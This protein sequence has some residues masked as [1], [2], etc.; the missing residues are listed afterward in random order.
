MK[1]NPQQISQL[2]KNKAIRLIV[3]QGEEVYL[4]EQYRQQIIHQY[5]HLYR[6]CTRV[7]LTIETANDW[8]LLGEQTQNYSLFAEFQ[9]FDVTYN[10]SSLDASGKTCLTHLLSSDNGDFLVIFTATN[11]KQVTALKAFDKNIAQIQAWSLKGASLIQWIKQQM[12]H[13]QL[14]CEEHAYALIAE[15]NEGNLLACAQTIEKLSLLHEKTR[16]TLEQVTAGLSFSAKFDVFKLAEQLLVGQSKSLRM[17]SQLKASG[18][19]PS[20]ILWALCKEI[21]T[22][23]KLHASMKQ[24]SLA[25]AMKQHKIWDS[26]KAS[27]QSALKRL[28]LGQCYHLLKRAQEVDTHIKGI[29]PLDPWLSVS[30]LCLEFITPGKPCRI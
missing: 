8:E 13:H 6:D 29:Q 11:L 9:I 24:Q 2:N 21:R 10:K 23:A 7:R 3:L 19:E 30:Q 4:L 14:S 18:T 26:K 17:L 20:L 1:V 12:N 22:L 15:M 27:Y 25:Q 28:P 16:L 5:T